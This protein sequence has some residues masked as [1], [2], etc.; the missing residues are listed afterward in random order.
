[1]HKYYLNQNREDEIPFSDAMISWYNNVY[2]PVIKIISEQLLLG[3]FPGRSAGDLY[4]WI[5]KHWDYLKKEYGSYSLADAAGDFSRKY[6]NSR[7]KF[8]RYMAL[9]ADKLAK[10]VKR[11]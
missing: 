5:V 6:G 1:M 8:L 9:L 4:V 11:G 3:N 10:K 7:G 2:T